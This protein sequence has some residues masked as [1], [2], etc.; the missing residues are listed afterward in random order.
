MTRDQLVKKAYRT[1]YGIEC[2]ST[3][4]ENL[5]KFVEEYGLLKSF[6][7]FNIWRVWSHKGYAPTSMRQ[8]R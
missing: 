7:Y 2:D 5:V 6:Y 1:T 4:L 3:V 8:L